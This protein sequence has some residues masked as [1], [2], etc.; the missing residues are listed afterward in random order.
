MTRFDPLISTGWDITKFCGL[1]LRKAALFTHSNDFLIDIWHGKIVSL[2]KR[3]RYY[4]C[5]AHKQIPPTLSCIT[6]ILAYYLT[7]ECGHL[8]GVAFSAE[9]AIRWETT[10][11]L[12]LKFLDF[13]KPYHQSQMFG[14]F[15]YGV[16]IYIYVAR[17]NLLVL[18]NELEHYKYDFIAKRKIYQTII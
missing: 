2:V 18:R 13:A 6:P 1:R 17:T 9:L 7:F 3:K 5:N 11:F 16:P 4:K 8:C 15:M 12:T 14:N 10:L